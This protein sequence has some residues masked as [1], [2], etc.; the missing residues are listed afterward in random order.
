MR[1]VPRGHS[2]ICIRHEHF[3]TAGCGEYVAQQ[4]S[5]ALDHGAPL[6]NQGGQGA[7]ALQAVA[8]ACA[9]SSGSATCVCLVAA[10][11]PSLPA[12]HKGF[13]RTSAVRV[14]WKPARRLSKPPGN[15]LREVCLKT[16]FEACLETSFERGSSGRR[17]GGS[18]GNRLGDGHMGL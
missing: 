13:V 16:G 18:L 10:S 12:Q 2:T 7:C 11:H 14:V 1:P 5:M 8:S 17:F 6:L 9:H 4:R 15:R 3:G